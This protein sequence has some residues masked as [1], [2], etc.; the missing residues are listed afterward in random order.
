MI[1]IIHRLGR[2]G[3]LQYLLIGFL[4]TASCAREHSGNKDTEIDNETNRDNTFAIEATYSNLAEIKMGELAKSKAS[5]E[6]VIQFADMMVKE[7]TAALQQLREISE[8]Q[9]INIPDTLQS[10]HRL[11]QDQVAAYEGQAFDSAYMHQQIKAHEK[12]QTLFRNV[13]TGNGDPIYA[14][15]AKTTLNHINSHLERAKEIVGSNWT[16]YI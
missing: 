9:G 16:C 11:M 14:D 4:L 15:Y 3:K 5:S 12:A 2:F 6:A 8:K 10:E 1:N 13:L 7:H